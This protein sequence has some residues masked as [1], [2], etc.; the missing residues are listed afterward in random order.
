MCGHVRPLLAE[1]LGT[2]LF[3]TIASLGPGPKV[4]ENILAS[5]FLSKAVTWGVSYALSS[6]L[7]GPH[8]V[9]NPALSLAMVASRQVIIFKMKTAVAQCPSHIFGKIISSKIAKFHLCFLF[10]A[11]LSTLP[12]RV[13]GQ[14]VG[15]SL[16]TIALIHTSPE[17]LHVDLS[18]SQLDPLLTPPPDNINFYNSI[19]QF[20]LASLLLS[21]L[22]C[23]SQGSAIYQAS[24]RLGV[25]SVNP[26]LRVSPWDWS[27]TIWERRSAWV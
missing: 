22:I 2:A 27:S 8:A 15:A 19:L 23:A 1:L 20:T 25:K 9:L 24:Q 11:K 13:V 12:A 10:Q 26:P 4:I 6:L 14:L 7:A 3:L 21:V 5:H 17:L 16:S 18:N